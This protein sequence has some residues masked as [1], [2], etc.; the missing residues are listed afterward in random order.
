MV[1]ES[2]ELEKLF[3]SEQTL[4]FTTNSLNR[5]WDNNTERVRVLNIM[6]LFEIFAKREV[7]QERKRMEE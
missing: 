4:F 2:A 3:S 7:E 6:E 1:V 5:V